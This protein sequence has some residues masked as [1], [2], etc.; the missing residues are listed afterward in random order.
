[1]RIRQIKPEFFGDAD[2]AALPFRTRLTYIGLWSEADDA[3]WLLVDATQIA[4]DLYGF[5]PRGRREGWVTEDLVRLQEAGCLEVLD[6]GHGCIPTLP[7]HQRFGGRPVYTVRD[8]H[9]R[10]CARVLADARPGT[11]G[12]GIGTER[13]GKERNGSARPRATDQ[14]IEETGGLKQRLGSFEAIVGGRP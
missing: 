13:N 9:A 2:M 8:A 14:E 7:R 5:D 3:G 12:N 1:M 4:H 11:V 10:G 6:C